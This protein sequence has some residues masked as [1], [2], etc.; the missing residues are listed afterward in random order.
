MEHDKMIMSKFDKIEHVAHITSCVFL[1][2]HYSKLPEREIGSL[3]FESGQML[4]TVGCCWSCCIMMTSDVSQVWVRCSVAPAKE[5]TWARINLTLL[6]IR[7]ALS[8]V[9]CCEIEC[10][11]NVIVLCSGGKQVLSWCYSTTK[12]SCSASMTNTAFLL[13]LRVY[14]LF[15]DAACLVAAGSPC[16]A[17]CS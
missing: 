13:F 9:R 11:L 12:L 5:D 4:T 16:A 10:R 2:I 3:Q 14:L 1:Q 15:L 7:I 6:W 17:S 8:F